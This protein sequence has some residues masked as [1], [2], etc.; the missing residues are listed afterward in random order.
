MSEFALIFPR[1]AAQST[2][3][4][5]LTDTDSDY[6]DYYP[7]LYQGTSGEEDFEPSSLDEEVGGC[8]P[9]LL[10]IPTPFRITPS[11]GHP[12]YVSTHMPLPH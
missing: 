7:L 2:E 1:I 11:S 3:C 8:S 9:R 5:E 6:A 4:I 12:A 10:F